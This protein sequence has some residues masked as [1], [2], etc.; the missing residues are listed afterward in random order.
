MTDE[1]V[2]GGQRP[3]P[4]T[5]AEE[6]AESVRVPSRIELAERI[7]LLER[8]L[9]EA[10]AASEEH[11]YNWQR[12]AADF[13]NFKRRTDDERATMGQFT[14]ALLIGKLL[15]VLD[16]FDRALES[17]PAEAHDAWIEGV[18][19]TERKLRGVLE[20]EGVTAIEAVG[21]PFDPNLHEAVAHEETADHPDNSV[22]GEVQRGYRLHDR[23]IRP[24]LVRVANNPKEH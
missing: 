23:V 3:R 4:K 8:E 14:N 22:I 15:T 12:S 20:S 24:S 10:R 9:S 21:E 1:P 2:N 6:R 11:L 18:K 16:D 5:R 13:A 17:V 7:E 19:L